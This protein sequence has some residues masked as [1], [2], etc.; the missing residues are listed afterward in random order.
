MIEVA[1]V[2]TAAMLLLALTKI[3]PA[4]FGKSVN[5]PHLIPFTSLTPTHY[6]IL[7]PSAIF[8]VWFWTERLA[9]FA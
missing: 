8:Q 1:F 5:L 4:M 9:L 7:Y 6:L 3:I 2:F